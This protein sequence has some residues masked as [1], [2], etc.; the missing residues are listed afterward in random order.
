MPLIQAM[1]RP[2]DASRPT[3]A[4]R[5]R[6]ARSGAPGG[7][8]PAPAHDAIG[9]RLPPD[10][11]AG[12]LQYP[13]SL[14]QPIG[15]DEDK[16]AVETRNHPHR[17]AS[18]P[19]RRHDRAQHP[20]RLHVMRLVTVPQRRPCILAGVVAPYHCGSVRTEHNGEDVRARNNLGDVCRTIKNVRTVEHPQRLMAGHGHRQIVAYE[21]LRAS[22][23]AVLE[24]LPEIT[25]MSRTRR[26]DAGRAGRPLLP[27]AGGPAGAGRGDHPAG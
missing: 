27:A 13:G 17:H 12:R 10:L 21:H 2:A 24:L 15:R 5:R 6:P 4:G 22:T 9:D 20:S 26:P 23:E 1:R 7:A 11:V 16:V 14:I 18:G 25:R 8:L 19:Q 3:P